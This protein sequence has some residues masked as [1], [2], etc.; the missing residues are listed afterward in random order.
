M[1]SSAMDLQ[2]V[3]QVEMEVEDGYILVRVN[4]SLFLLK[5]FTYSSQVR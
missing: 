2:E 1:V 5:A 4:S 3:A